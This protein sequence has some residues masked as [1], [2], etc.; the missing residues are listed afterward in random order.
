MNKSNIKIFY[1]NLFF[2][3][4]ETTVNEFT[5]HNELLFIQIGAW[6]FKDFCSVGTYKQL[7]TSLPEIA[8]INTSDATDEMKQQL[9]QLLLDE[10]N[11]IVFFNAPFDL[12]HL[13]KWLYPEVFYPGMKLFT[14]S[15]D[16]IKCKVWDLYLLCKIIHPGYK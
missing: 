13:L 16:Y 1:G 14:Y 11:Q 7:K 10:G 6:K 2:I 9:R 8:I 15:R 12:S 5:V 4:C 3:D